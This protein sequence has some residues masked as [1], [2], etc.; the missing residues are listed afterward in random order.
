MRTQYSD[1]ERGRQVHHGAQVEVGPDSPLHGWNRLPS[2]RRS[3][4]LAERE[5]IVEMIPSL[6][7]FARALTSSAAEADD[8]LQETL[9]R[10]LAN[11]HQFT[12]GTNLRAWLFRIQRNA[13]YSNY[14]KRSRE[15]VTPPEKIER[16]VA[17]VQEW[18]L[19]VEDLSKA[20][21]QIP[22]DQKEAL[23]LVAASDL[24]YEEAA[25]VCDCALGTIKSRVSRARARLLLIL[26][27]DHHEDY[28]AEGGD[29]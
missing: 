4:E 5:R 13:F 18:P 28:I 24:S 23:L 6:R 25:E 20:I 8:L 26:Q 1:Q 29:H 12:P 27:V 14:R 21:E 3:S 9:T 11:L 7:A 15:V 16:T 17:P 22:E 2:S 19:K 10:A